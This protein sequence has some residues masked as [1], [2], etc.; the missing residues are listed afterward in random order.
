MLALAHKAYNHS[1]WQHY[2]RATRD[3]FQC[4]FQHPSMQQ[5]D[6]TT[7]SLLNTLPQLTAKIAESADVLSSSY[8]MALV[9]LK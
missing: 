3:V 9:S 4:V 6:K 2:G 7:C 1:S 5:H 8:C